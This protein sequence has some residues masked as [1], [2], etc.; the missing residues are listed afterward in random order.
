MFVQVEPV[1]S[2]TLPGGWVAVDDSTVIVESTTVEL[3]QP[4]TDEN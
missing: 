4:S 1:E 3:V 2:I